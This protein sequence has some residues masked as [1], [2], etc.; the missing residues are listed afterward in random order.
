MAKK[1]KARRK[2]RHNVKALLAVLEGRK[3]LVTNLQAHV[4]RLI[5]QANDLRA[6]RRAGVEARTRA[7]IAKR[8]ADD[9]KLMRSFMDTVAAV[10]QLPDRVMVMGGSRSESGV[11][12]A[13]TTDMRSL[14][15]L[16]Q[17]IERMLEREDAPVEKA[18]DGEAVVDTGNL[19]KSIGT[20]AADL[21]DR[22]QFKWMHAPD[23]RTRHEREVLTI[24][25]EGSR[26]GASASWTG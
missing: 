17:A 18:T 20:V 16:A 7:V 1:P 5:K 23:E 13:Y 4:D 22:M 6:E 10:N 14:R 19:R 11:V 9:E 3:A 2:V 25:Q 26:P 21:K 24:L 15:A 12:E 8:K